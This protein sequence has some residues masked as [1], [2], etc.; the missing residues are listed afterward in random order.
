MSKKRWKHIKPEPFLTECVIYNFTVK[1]QVFNLIRHFLAPTLHW[2]CE[3]WYFEQFAFVFEKSMCH[4]L[5]KLILRK[6]LDLDKNDLKTKRLRENCTHN[7]PHQLLTYILIIELHVSPSWPNIILLI[8][9]TECLSSPFYISGF[10]F[11]HFSSTKNNKY[12]RRLMPYLPAIRTKIKL[13][14][15]NPIKSHLW[16]HPHNIPMRCIYVW[17]ISLRLKPED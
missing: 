4:W 12:P 9:E 3:C 1:N 5:A 2:K 7:S 16:C 13:L 14:T 10:S 6:T 15:D 8:Q 11:I 17:T